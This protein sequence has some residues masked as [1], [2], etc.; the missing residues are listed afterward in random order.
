MPPV[1]VATAAG[2][3]PLQVQDV[4]ETLDALPL[5][6]DLSPLGI[7]IGVVAADADGAV[8]LEYT[9]PPRLQKAVA[10]QVRTALREAD[11][12]VRRADFIR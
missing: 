6:S 2:S 1:S 9:G 7:T 10:L 4:R 8:R 3:G 5:L 12:R 11:P